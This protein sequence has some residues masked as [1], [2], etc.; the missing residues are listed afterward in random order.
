MVE[1]HDRRY[2]PSNR[3]SLS[4]GRPTKSRATRDEMDDVPEVSEGGPRRVRGPVLTNV[5]YDDV[6]SPE[7][8]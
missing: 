6:P 4:H 8:P 2:S 3:Q 7:L 1:V 5:A